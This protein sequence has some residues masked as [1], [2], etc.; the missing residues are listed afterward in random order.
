[1]K[2]LLISALLAL[3]PLCA[4]VWSTAQDVNDEACQQSIQ[5]SCTKCHGAEKICNELGASR[6]RLAGNN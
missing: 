5:T 6:C 1:M 2:K 3:L 4:A